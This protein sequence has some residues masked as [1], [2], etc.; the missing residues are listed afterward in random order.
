MSSFTSSYFKNTVH[1]NAKTLWGHISSIAGYVEQTSHVISHQI[2]ISELTMRYF[3]VICSQDLMKL[4]VKHITL[5]DTTRYLHGNAQPRPH[6]V[7]KT[8]NIVHQDFMRFIVRFIQR[9]TSWVTY[10]IH[11]TWRPHAVLNKQKNSTS[12]P[13][14]EVYREIHP[15]HACA[16]EI[17]REVPTFYVAHED[18]MRLH[19]WTIHPPIKVPLCVD[20]TT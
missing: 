1:C 19:V 13:D 9:N 6:E 16:R 12:R 18:L 8:H 5:R 10:I 20:F 4:I 14:D 11:S 7:L 3:N 2:Y 17:H 15:A